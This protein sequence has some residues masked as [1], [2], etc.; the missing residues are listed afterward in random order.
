MIAS[1]DDAGTSPGAAV[2]LTVPAAASRTVSAADLE[3]GGDGLA[4]ARGD[5]AGKWRLRVAS[6]VPI[7]AM[8]LLSSHTGHLTNASNAPE[9]RAR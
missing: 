9:R 3:S 2:V 6:D 5:G 8:S 4:G 7:L 1:I